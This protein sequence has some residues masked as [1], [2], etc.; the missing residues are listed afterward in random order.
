MKVLN[1]LEK[2]KLTNKIFREINTSEIPAK[3]KITIEIEIYRGELK[4]LEVK[5]EV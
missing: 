5:K 1:Q 3:C 4:T 2:T